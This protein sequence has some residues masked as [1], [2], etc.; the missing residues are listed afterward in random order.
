MCSDFSEKVFVLHWGSDHNNWYLG[1]AEW[2]KVVGHLPS[3]HEAL[4]TN[5]STTKKKIGILYNTY[6][7]ASIILK[8]LLLF[9]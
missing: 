6:S 8:T 9:I 7:V 4:S 1:L 2:L 3:K 5:P